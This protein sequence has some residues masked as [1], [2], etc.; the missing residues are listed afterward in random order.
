MSLWFFDDSNPVAHRM[1][2][3]LCAIIEREGAYA[4]MLGYGVRANPYIAT[5][6]YGKAW[7]RGWQRGQDAMRGYNAQCAKRTTNQK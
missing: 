7:L 5:T 4:G 6:S 1:T 3:K 2:A